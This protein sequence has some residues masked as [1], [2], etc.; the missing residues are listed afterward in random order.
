MQRRKP[1]IK[2]KTANYKREYKGFLIKRKFKIIV[3]K[4]L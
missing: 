4:K 1:E 3:A 2:E